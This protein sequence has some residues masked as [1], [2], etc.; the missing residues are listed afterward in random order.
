MQEKSHLRTKFKNLRKEIDTESVSAAICKNIRDFQPYEKAKNVMLFYPTKFEIN[1]LPLL[2]D[3]KT[4]YFPRVSGNELEVCPYSNNVEF[5]KSVFN[6]NEPCSEAVSANVLDLI[7]VP[8]LA[9]DIEGY[10]LGYGGGFYD[11][12]LPICSNAVTVVPMYDDFIQETLPRE[13]FDRK[14]DYIITNVKRLTVK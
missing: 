14:V 12:F 3:N 6:I 2:N 9:V 1:L 13:K 7:F 5:K 10:R 4:F 8:A 11:R